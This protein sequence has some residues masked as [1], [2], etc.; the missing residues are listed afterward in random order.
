[1]RPIFQCDDQYIPYL[2][3]EFTLVY[4]FATEDSYYC[5]K[6]CSL[7]IKCKREIFDDSGE[8]NLFDIISPCYWGNTQNLLEPLH[9]Y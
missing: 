7:H 2:I 8:Q 4:E 9:S 6:F 3:Y 5:D 1:M